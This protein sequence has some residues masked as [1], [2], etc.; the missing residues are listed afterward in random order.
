MV[1]APAVPAPVETPL[2]AL[3]PALIAMT[4]LQAL[5]ALALFAPGVLAP[6]LGIDRASLGL[7]PMAAFAVGVVTSLWGGVLAGR[8]GAFRLASLCALAV[9]AAMGLAGLASSAGGA[10]TLVLAG[11]AMGFA[12]GPETP[13]SSAILGRLAREADRPLVF[14]V[15]QTGNQIGAMVGSLTLPFLAALVDPRLGYLAIAALAVAAIVGFE[16]LRP[17]Y[18]P[19][20]RANAA[21]MRVVEALALL[22]DD[23]RLARYAAASA[24][25]SALQ[26]A[27]NTF[28]VLFAVEELALSH[29]TA[30]VALATAQG[31]GLLG[32]LGWGLLGARVVAPRRLVAALGLGMGAAALAVAGIGPL[33]PLWGLLALAFLFGLTASGWNGIFLA[34]VAR[35]APPARMAEATGAVLMAS[36]AGL[37][38]GPLLIVGAS[39]VGGLAAAYALI[40]GLCALAG[41]ALFGADR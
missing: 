28:F 29:V 3:L 4:G 19:L 10:V 8:F 22:R 2:P 38:V 23:R 27:L 41:L 7:Y 16:L 26:M 40:G 31:G 39:A 11:L 32:R 6:P 25:Y 13:A 14:S 30:G 35:L 24:P 9:I 37:L 34:E 5:M 36:Y 20:T 1:A 15:R 21:P 18:D 33:L 17:A 12:F